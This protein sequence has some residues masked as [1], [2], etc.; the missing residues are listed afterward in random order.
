MTKSRQSRQSRQFL[1]PNPSEIWQKSRLK[2]PDFVL[3]VALI[4]T[5]SIPQTTKKFV[6]GNGSPCL[7]QFGID[8]QTNI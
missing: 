4:H 6:E 5:N 3:E 2:K 8:R 1:W 7:S